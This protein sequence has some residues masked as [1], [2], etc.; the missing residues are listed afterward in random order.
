MKISDLIRELQRFQSEYGDLGIG[1]TWEGTE[2][3]IEVYYDES[4]GTVWI[5]A[6]GLHDRE[7]PPDVT[8]AKFEVGSSEA[9]Y[10]KIY[11]S[12]G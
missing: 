2:R 12:P 10:R 8:A 7:D 1:A 9:W 5:N 3:G 11:G 6:D 4:D